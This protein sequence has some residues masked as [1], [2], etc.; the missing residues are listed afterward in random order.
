MAKRPGFFSAVFISL[1]LASNSFASPDAN[2]ETGAAQDAEKVRTALTE[3]L[4]SSNSPDSRCRAITLLGSSRDVEVKKAMAGLA[5]DPEVQVCATRV[6]GEQRNEF[7]EE[8]LV[9]NVEDYLNAAGSKGPFEDNLKKRLSAINSIW[10]LGE[11]GNPQLMDKLFSFYDSADDII[12]VNLIIGM[13]KLKDNS[14]AAPYLYS[15]AGDPRETEIVRATAFEI[16]EKT[17]SPARLDN[18]V[19]SKKVGAQ[20]GDIFWTGGVIGSIFSSLSP[21]MPIGHPGI[22]AGTKTED[23]RIKLVISDCVPDYFVPP[24]VRIVHSWYYFTHHYKYPYYGNRTSK[25][26]PTPSQRNAIANLVLKMGTQGLR[27]DNLHLSQKGPKFDCVGYAEHIY[28]RVGLDPTDSSYETGIGWP[29]TPYEQFDSLVAN[30]E[31]DM[32][33]QV[34]GGM[35]TPSNKAPFQTVKRFAE[36]F[37]QTDVSEPEISL[38]TA[39]EPVN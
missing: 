38:E 8:L 9:R 18:L 7:S 35:T 32:V 2:R 1:F 39:P 4:D 11:L 10:A 15:I 13:G 36:S 26:R 12:K 24:G 23:G 17:G 25:T 21:D 34:P 20:K 6:M 3:A 30:A 22:F 16:L 37:G 29:L 31:S 27:Y 5:A 19:P 14:K 28:E 33:E